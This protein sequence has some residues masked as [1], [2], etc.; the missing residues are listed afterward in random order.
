MVNIKK[1]IV[2]PL[3]LRIS[4][5]DGNMKIRKNYM[6][7]DR[8]S[9]MEKSCLKFTLHNPT[10]TFL[11]FSGNI[12]FVLFSFLLSLWCSRQADSLH[13]A[14]HI[15]SEVTWQFVISRPRGVSLIYEWA[16]VAKAKSPY[17]RILH[18]RQ[19][20]FS[21]WGKIWNF[22]LIF[23]GPWNLI[24][25]RAPSSYS[26]T[27][28]ANKDI[29]DFWSWV[30]PFFI[31]R[32]CDWIM[33]RSWDFFLWDFLYFPREGKGWFFQGCF[34]IIRSGSWIFI[35]ESMNKRPCHFHLLSSLAEPKAFSISL[36]CLKIA[37]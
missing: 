8:L 23:S 37:G 24:F 28:V 12:F 26:S 25:T 27:E 7:S 9:S 20:I 35:S 1:S 2:P 19:H 18:F 17:H 4:L 33:T 32:Q 3:Y 13:F 14:W 34:R 31:D 15:V 5:L 29:L 10:D 16:S 6:H 21:L 11:T 36:W 22:G 30:F